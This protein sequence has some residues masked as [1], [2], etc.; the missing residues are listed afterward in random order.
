MKVMTFEA[1]LAALQVKKESTLIEDAVV[2]WG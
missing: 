1:P 2:H